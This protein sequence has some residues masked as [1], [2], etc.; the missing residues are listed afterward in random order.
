MTRLGGDYHDMIECDDEKVL[1]FIGDATGHG[2][3]AAISMAMAKSVMLH[4]SLEH[5][6]QTSLMAKL[7]MLF[8]RLRAQGV[9]DFMTATSILL[10][11]SSSEVN[12]INAGHCYPILLKNGMDKGMLLSEVKGLPPGFSRSLKLFPVTM[13][14]EPGDILMLFTDGLVES[15]NATGELFG[16]ESLQKILAET[17]NDDLSAHLEAILAAVKSWET[18]QN[19]DQTVILVRFL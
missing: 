9:K 4:E 3:P 17:R 10:D 15:C 6:D 8:A 7:H 5:I 16:F 13:Q 1:A 14:L 11:S 12:F 18:E 2:I 19:D